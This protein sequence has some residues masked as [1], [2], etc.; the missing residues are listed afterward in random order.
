L[1]LRRRRRQN[2]FGT[3]FDCG[4]LRHFARVCTEQKLKISPPIDLDH[5]I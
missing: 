1:R 5:A 2:E 4:Q 3:Y